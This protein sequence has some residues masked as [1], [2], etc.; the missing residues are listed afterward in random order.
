MLCPQCGNACAPDTAFCSK[1][2]A[3]LTPASG[4]A[5]VAGSHAASIA[6]PSVVYAGFWRRY[7]NAELKGGYSRLF[8]R[9]DVLV[10]LKA[11]SFDTVYGWRSLQE[12]KLSDK[13]KSQGLT[14]TKIMGPQ[15]IR[16]FLMFYQRLTEWILRE[17]PGRADILIPLN[18]E[19]RLLGV[20]IRVP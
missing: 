20:E 5:P 2:G 12:K 14:G 8:G 10:M 17:M 9:I 1:C 6:M 7:V 16:R 3:S 11:P 15:E 18:E 19:H 4:I 13:V